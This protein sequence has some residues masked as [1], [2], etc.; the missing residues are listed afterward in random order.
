MFLKVI[1]MMELR[2][3]YNFLVKPKEKE[4]YPED[5][6]LL[7]EHYMKMKNLNSLLRELNYTR[8]ER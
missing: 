6:A 7:R 8:L 1:G 3:S 2:N 4:P 5:K